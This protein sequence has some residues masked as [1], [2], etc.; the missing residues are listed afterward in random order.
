MIQGA[1]AAS[2][3]IHTTNTTKWL[4]LA[5]TG[6][7]M[8]FLL[9][10]LW[11]Q[12]IYRPKSGERFLWNL[13][14]STE[15]TMAWND[16][17]C[18]KEKQ[19]FANTWSLRLPISVCTME[20]MSL[21]CAPP[22]MCLYPLLVLHI[23]WLFFVFPPQGRGSGFP[24]RRR[25]RGAGLSGRAGRGRARGKNGVSPG[26]NPGVCAVSWLTSWHLRQILHNMQSSVCFPCSWRRGCCIVSS[27]D[28]N[29]R[30]N[31]LLV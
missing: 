16:S 26:M 7:S 28:V 21:S 30:V 22:T 31:C 25:P 3:C 20:I 24:G 18:V 13:C 27:I 5:T 2:A 9:C 12:N 1:L 17:G 15:Q 29:D 19:T 6:W 4:Y 10:S 11:I 23:F 14:L 8:L